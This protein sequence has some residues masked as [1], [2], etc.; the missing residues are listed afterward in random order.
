VSA[1]LWCVI[2]SHP[3]R[4]SRSGSTHPR[5]G[6]SRSGTDAHAG[7][8]QAVGR[9]W[10]GSCRGATASTAAAAALALAL[11]LA[12]ALPFS[13]AGS[14]PAA[15]PGLSGVPS[16]LLLQSLP[17]LHRPSLGNL[18]GSFELSGVP[19]GFVPDFSC[20]FPLLSFLPCHLP[21]VPP[22]LGR[23]PTTFFIRVIGVRHASVS[24]FTSIFFL[25][26]A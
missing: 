25:T 23:S 24:V 2:T 16:S 13:L 8:A 5:F 12:S 7:T 3:G 19:F 17:N 18:Q 14:F 10:T 26:F 1:I 15:S 11:E 20:D 4:A 6:N 22:G 21:P 9:T